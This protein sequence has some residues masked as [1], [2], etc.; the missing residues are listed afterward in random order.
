VTFTVTPYRSF[1]YSD[2]GNLDAGLEVLNAVGTVIAATPIDEGAT[3]GSCTAVLTPGLT[4]Y[5]RVS[6][7]GSGTPQSNPPTGYTSYGSLGA[8]TISGSF[9]TQTYVPP[10][11]TQQ[12]AN[13][14][15]SSGN[16][17]TFTVVATGTPAPTYAWQRLP[18]GTGS[19][20]V[21]LVNDATYSGATSATLTIAATTPS[22]RGDHYRCIATNPVTATT[23][24]EAVLTFFGGVGATDFNADGAPD[25]LL[26]NATTGQRV[27]WLMGGP[28]N[29]FV[30]QG[31]DLGILDSSWHIVR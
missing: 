30:L 5:L 29:A 9:S 21:T 27:L 19:G 14:T 13:R 3:I 22:M 28:N 2:G 24:T 25:I 17:A 10:A 16:P 1:H 18:G 6:G 8:Y 15:V 20:W 4:Y 12:P 26:E 23:S 11:F 31:L 7:A